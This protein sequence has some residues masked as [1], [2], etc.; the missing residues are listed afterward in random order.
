MQSAMLGGILTAALLG[1]SLAGEISVTGVGT[2]TASPDM[3]S[4]EAAVVTQ[5]G[6]AAEAMSSNSQR[7]TEVMRALKTQKIETSDIQTSRINVSPQY[8]Q[9]RRPASQNPPKIIGYV[10]T[11]QLHIRVRNLSALGAVLDSVVKAGS[12]QINSIRFDIDDKTELLDYARSQ[13][14]F[15]A[16]RRAEVYA[17]AAGAKLGNVK[18]IREAGIPSPQPRP[19]LRAMAADAVPIA[20]GE[21]SLSVSVTVVYALSAE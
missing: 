16:R 10:A 13:A 5:A 19:M 17:V 18:S 7:V 9:Q 14:I 21:Q 2:V 8:E 4:F 11:N 20:P 12:N 15:D 6:T 3:A 1:T